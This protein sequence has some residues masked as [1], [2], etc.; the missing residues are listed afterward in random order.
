MPP[1]FSP[2]P[3]DARQF[4]EQYDA[5]YS[6]FAVMY[7][8]IVKFFPLWRN[9]LDNALPGIHGPKVLEIS[10][11]TGYLLTRYAGQFDSY[12]IDLNFDLARITRSNLL[13]QNLTAAIQV[14][15][16]EYLP[17]LSGFFD[18]VVNT[19]AFSAYPHGERAM[20][21]ITRVLKP[22][23]RLVMVDVNYPRDANRIGTL[24]VRGWM[25]SGDIIRDIPGLLAGFGYQFT[26]QEVGG[27]GSVHLYVASKPI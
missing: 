26:D 22:G 12:S 15:D 27:F 1:E 25:A 6:R 5:L 13:Q 21:E 2:E 11:G 3:S 9:W 16:V 23:G 14:A 24:L 4:T 7:D 19:M 10:C 17:Y 20:A 8:R 18:T